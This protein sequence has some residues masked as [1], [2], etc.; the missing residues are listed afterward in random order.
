MLRALLPIYSEEIMH[1]T[2]NPMSELAKKLQKKDTK[3]NI[4]IAVVSILILFIFIFT[5][6]RKHYT[7]CFYMQNI[8]GATYTYKAPKTNK[9]KITIPTKIKGRTITSLGPWAY[10]DSE[11]L[12]EVVIPNTITTIEKNAFRN[13]PA[14]TTITIP[15]SVTSIGENAFYESGYYNDPS[16]WDGD[17]LYLDGWLIAIKETD[18]PRDIEVNEGT[19][20]IVDRLFAK[21]K[22]ITSVTL[23]DSLVYL[24]YKAFEENEV[25]ESIDTGDG[26]VTIGEFSFSGCKQLKTVRIG[27]RVC[28][29]KW[30]AFNNCEKLESVI[31][32]NPD[33]WY[34]SYDANHEDCYNINVSNTEQFIEDLNEEYFYCFLFRE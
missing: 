28:E 32:A 17:E 24:G 10:G 9:T 18:T 3:S 6:Y 20:G 7:N 19:K 27:E 8:D 4:V 33:N 15:S 22:D 31:F 11:N 21:R 23:P 13:C 30:W 5:A 16:N 25:I 2:L 14:L 34:Y 1:P 26:L 12:E 29:I